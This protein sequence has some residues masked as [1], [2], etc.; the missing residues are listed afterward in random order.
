MSLFNLKDKTSYISFVVFERKCNCGENYIGETGWNITV[1][2]DEH[3]DKGKNSELAKHLYQFPE[4]RF[5][6]KVFRKV[7]NKIRLRKIHKSYYLM[8]LGPTV[9]IQLELNSL[10]LFQ[11]EVSW[12]NN[13]KWLLVSLEFYRL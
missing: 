9:N 6:W 8:C 13:L 7:P 5:N 3:C 11:N 4:Y 10:T 2:W 1:R 12:N